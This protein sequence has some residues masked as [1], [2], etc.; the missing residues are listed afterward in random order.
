MR[1]EGSGII[2]KGRR[3]EKAEY[4]PKI[5]VYYDQSSSWSED[6]IAVGNEAIGVLKNYVNRGEIVVNLFYFADH[7]SGNN[8][9]REIGGCTTAGGEIIRHIKATKPDNIIMMT[10]NDMEYGRNEQM[11]D[12]GKVTVP[13]AV[14]F[15]FRRAISQ[16]VQDHIK[17][18]KQNMVFLI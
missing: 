8:D 18:R 14:W 13:G 16:G 9:Y 12:E 7:V 6:D 3:I 15:L 11:F 1:Y 10:D 17:G 2:R 4:I 5:N